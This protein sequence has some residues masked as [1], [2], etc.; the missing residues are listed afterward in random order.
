MSFV[1]QRFSK[2][3]AESTARE[4]SLFPKATLIKWSAI[5]GLMHLN[6]SLV[7]YC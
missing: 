1:R 4:N 7:S 3:Y 6:P 5:Q 2:E